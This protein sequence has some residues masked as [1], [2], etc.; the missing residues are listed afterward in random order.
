MVR[1]VHHLCRRVQV[2]GR[3][4]CVTIVAKRD[5]RRVQTATLAVALQPPARSSHRP[6]A[7][8]HTAVASG[9][10]GDRLGRLGIKSFLQQQ[11]TVHPAAP[12]AP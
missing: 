11:R 12:W 7:Q 4:P 2:G 9:Q 1:S 5:H 6:G 3:T 10:P 8:V